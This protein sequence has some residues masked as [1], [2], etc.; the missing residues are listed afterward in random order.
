MLTPTHSLSWQGDLRRIYFSH[1]LS[2]W[3]DRMWEFAVALFLID[4]MPNSVR[5]VAPPPHPRP[6]ADSSS[7]FHR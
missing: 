5:P 6:P 4:I 2:A 7:Y 3:G 1:F